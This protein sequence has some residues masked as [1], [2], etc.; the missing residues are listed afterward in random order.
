MVKGHSAAGSSIPESSLEKRFE[1]FYMPF[2][3]FINDQKTSNALLLLAT[4]AAIIL[5]N[6]PWQA[7]YFEINNMIS[8]IYIG[9]WSL[10]MTNQAWINEGLMAMFF[11]II[12]LEVKRELLIG[13]LT[14]FKK[15]LTILAAAIGGMIV[16]ALIYHGFNVNLATEHGWGIPMATDTAFAIGV[17]TLLGRR[18]PASAIT[19]L[20][21]LAIFDDLGAVLVI[22]IFYTDGLNLVSL[23]YALI[24]FLLMVIM[25]HLGIRQVLSYLLGGVMLWIFIHDSG[26]HA[27]VSGVLAAL[28]VPAKPKHNVHWF[29][30]KILHLIDKFKK[31]IRHSKK[32]N[33]KEAIAVEQ[34]I[35]KDIE[36]V[37]ETSTTPLQ[38]WEKT[39]RRPIALLVLPLFALSNAGITIQLESFTG[40]FN[41]ASFRGIFLGLILGKCIGISLFTWIVIRSGL[42][43]LPSQMSM[44][45]VYGLGMLGG[46]GFTMSI[47]IA[48]IG[49]HELTSALSLAKTAI[50]L[51]SLSAGIV[52]Y[53]WL[54]WIAKGHPLENSQRASHE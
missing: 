29:T 9:N 37:A 40:W 53:F 35:I 28:T 13:E 4:I 24:T 38:R 31:A 3:E 47:F 26:V 51:S 14:S 36:R 2:R 33:N 32:L 20:M 30:K 48:S 18:V 21:T 45:H 1:T 27:S 5:A 7:R 22:A 25:N 8:G 39:V 52:G 49:F 12:G 54:F 43:Q 15:N 50:L 19:F 11:Y 42:G 44:Q 6:S 46:M 41:H 34:D 23:Y 10:A 17:L 16:P